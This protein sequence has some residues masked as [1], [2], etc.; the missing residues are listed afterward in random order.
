MTTVYIG[1]QAA[2]DAD[3]ELQGSLQDFV[4]WNTG[5][6]TEDATILYNS[7]SWLDIHS[8]PS[9]SSGLGVCRPDN[10]LKW[11]VSTCSTCAERLAGRGVEA[12]ALD[13]PRHLRALV[14]LPSPYSI[15]SHA[16]Q[17]IPALSS[18]TARSPN[19]GRFACVN[20][21]AYI[22]SGPVTLTGL[23]KRECTSWAPWM[24]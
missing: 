7:G 6:N 19:D 13:A 17:S 8:H 10:R 12:L 3:G 16:V 14:L 18:P 9:A 2:A 24:F 1:D 15:S 11:C 5:L 20:A 21:C 4:I 23:R 22:S